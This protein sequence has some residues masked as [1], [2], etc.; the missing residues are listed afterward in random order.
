VKEEN[1]VLGF[2]LKGS[3]FHKDHQ[4]I[5]TE[6]F[7]EAG[8][9]IP[10]LISSVHNMNE[11]KEWDEDV[12]SGEMLELKEEGQIILFEQVNKSSNKYVSSRQLIEKKFYFKHEGKHYVFFSSLP[13]DFK[14]K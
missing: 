6:M 9:S 10:A 13:D 8:T 4:L 12:V 3:E 2:Q 11:R 7:Y 5:F 14:E 1:F